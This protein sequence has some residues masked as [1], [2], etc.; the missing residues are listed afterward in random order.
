MDATP[1]DRHA[2]S[3]EALTRTL[4]HHTAQLLADCAVPDSRYSRPAITKQ[5]LDIANTRAVFVLREHIDLDPGSLGEQWRYSVWLVE[6]VAPPRQLFE[7]HAFY[8]TD[9]PRGHCFAGRDPS[10]GLIELRADAVVIEASRHGGCSG[11]IASAKEKLQLGFDGSVTEVETFVDQ[12]K[13]MVERCASRLGYDYISALQVVPGRE[14]VVIKFS[15]ENGSDYGYDTVFVVWRDSTGR[16]QQ[17][18]VVR[19]PAGE[20][21]QLGEVCEQPQG[22]EIAYSVGSAQSRIRIELG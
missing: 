15:T 2:T 9:V 20:Y 12:A 14:A 1:N 8:R 18:A 10:I 5:I 22:I 7:D 4:H 21:L 3:A 19:G 11:A 16:M 6:G 17:R 13:N